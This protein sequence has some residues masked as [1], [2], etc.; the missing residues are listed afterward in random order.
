M[1]LSPS[2]LRVLN[3]LSDEEGKFLSEGVDSLVHDRRKKR[4]LTK[5]YDKFSTR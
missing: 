2:G 3:L 5:Y 1:E 4:S